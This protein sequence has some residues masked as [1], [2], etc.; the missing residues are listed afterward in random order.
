M[1]FK[2]NHFPSKQKPDPVRTVYTPLEMH[3]PRVYSTTS[4]YSNVRLVRTKHNLHPNPFVPQSFENTRSKE[5]HETVNRRIIP[6]SIEDKFYIVTDI[7]AN[8][9]DMIAQIYYNNPNLWWVIAEA[10]PEL[11]FN[12]YNVPRGTSVRIP[13]TTTLYKS[14]GVLDG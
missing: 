11:R 5:Y 1:A 6:Q 9:L 2:I 3:P 10:N 8:R 7:T 4:R 14:G 12:P 13:S